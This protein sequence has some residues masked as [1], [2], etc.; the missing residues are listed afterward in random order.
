MKIYKI[1]NFVV[2]E[3]IYYL[4]GEKYFIVVDFGS[5]WDV[6]CQIIENINKLICVIFFYLCLL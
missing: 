6:I 3:N 1:V 2:Y 5:D 4:E